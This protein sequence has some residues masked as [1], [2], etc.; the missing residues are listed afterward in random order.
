MEGDW[1]L[2]VL[3][4]PRDKLGFITKTPKLLQIMPNNY[5]SN[6][7]IF[8][9]PRNT[10]K[11]SDKMKCTLYI[12]ILMRIQIEY[13]EEAIMLMLFCLHLDYWGET[14]IRKL[15]PNRLIQ[16]VTT[17]HITLV[18]CA[19]VFSWDKYV[20]SFHIFSQPYTSKTSM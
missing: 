10:T 7:M 18:V 5:I 3:L 6:Q 15:K 20:I 17:T 13:K 12:K 2:F 8:Y 16:F 14:T 19:F 1:L 4:F 11:K 9:F